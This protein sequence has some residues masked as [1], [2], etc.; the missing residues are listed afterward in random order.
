VKY[1]EPSRS[2]SCDS[3]LPL[4]LAMMA[5]PALLRLRTELKEKS[6]AG[7]A[8]LMCEMAPVWQASRMA[9]VTVAGSDSS[10]WRSSG[11]DSSL[12]PRAR[13]PARAWP[14]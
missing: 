9:R 1:D 3:S 6:A 5:A 10:S 14:E 2:D 13:A 4:L 12:A 7:A 8:P 11:S